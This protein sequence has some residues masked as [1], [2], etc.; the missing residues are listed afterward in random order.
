MGLNYLKYEFKVLQVQTCQP[1][2][3]KELENLLNDGWEIERADRAGDGYSLIYILKC[4]I[5]S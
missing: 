3:Q 5:D 1:E 4:I 2:S